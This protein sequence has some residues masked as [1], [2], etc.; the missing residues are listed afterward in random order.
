V[1][2]TTFKDLGHYH[3]SQ[4][5]QFLWA[6][7]TIPVTLMLLLIQLVLLV[8]LAMVL[9]V[10]QELQHKDPQ[11]SLNQQRFKVLLAGTHRLLPLHII[12]VLL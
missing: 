1:A 6:F 11:T 9:V 12:T 2:L 8:V 4:D 3:L 7:G 5:L 10:A